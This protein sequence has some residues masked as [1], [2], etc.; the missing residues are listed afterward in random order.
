MSFVA[1]QLLD[2]IHSKRAR[3]G[4]VGLGYVG[5]PLAVELARAGFFTTGIDVDT[6]KTE[7]IN[8]GTS[9]IADVKSDELASFVASGRLRAT[10]NFAAVSSLDTINI[11]VPTPLR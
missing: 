1:D 11:C 3:I 6:R 4:V 5:L 9:Y 2:R 7:A 8:G 10:T